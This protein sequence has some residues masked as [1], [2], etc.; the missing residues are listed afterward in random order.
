MN[1]YLIGNTANPV[2]PGASN[3]NLPP[4][5]ASQLNAQFGGLDFATAFNNPTLINLA[6]QMMSDPSMQD[7]IHNLR[8]QIDGMNNMEGIFEV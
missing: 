3:V 1:F 4:N 2:L 7:T 8:S 6:T 5:I